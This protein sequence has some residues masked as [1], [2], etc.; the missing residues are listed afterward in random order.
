MNLTGPLVGLAPM[1]GITDVVYRSIVNS[2]AKPDLFFTEFVSAEGLSRGGVKLYDQLLFLP[3]QHPIIGQLFGKDPDSF[4]QAAIILSHLGFDGIDLNMGCPAKTV[5]H[6]GSGAALIDQPKLA[7]H[8]ITSVQ[9]AVADFKSK[10]ISLNDLGLNQ[11]T[12]KVITRNIKFSQ[13]Q[14]NFKP[15]ISVKTRLGINSFNPDWVPFLLTHKLDLI[16]VHLRTLKQGYSGTADWPR[17]KQL[18][19]LFSGTTTK[20]FGNGDIHTRSQ[21]LEYIDRYHLAGVLIGRAAL[22]N[23]WLFTD[24]I[25]RP[26]DRFSAILAHAQIFQDIFPAR[27]FEPLRKHFLAYTK[28]LKNA[29]QLRS[30]LIRANNLS[31]LLALETHFQD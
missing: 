24:Q 20:L 11:K 6:H 2:I 16:T 23:P 7:S 22:G 15:T 10:K 3:D 29:K 13:S 27:R 9:K 8:L 18:Q 30:Y 21:A 1:D 19:P 12:Q 5:I 17:M 28:T 4:Y 31:D 25:P 26:Q 14:P